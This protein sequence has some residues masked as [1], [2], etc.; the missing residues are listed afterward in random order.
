MTATIPKPSKAQLEV[1]RKMRDKA[2]YLDG[3]GCGAPHLV[4]P[5]GFW[6]PLRPRTACILVRQGWIASP[7]NDKFSGSWRIPPAG[8]AALEAA[9]EESHG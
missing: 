4:S 5:L 6:E 7:D 1:L 2:W 9:T 3:P 8:L